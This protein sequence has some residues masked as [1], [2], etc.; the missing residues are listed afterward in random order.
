MSYSRDC[1]MSSHFHFVFL[2]VLIANFSLIVCKK[3]EA[4]HFVF[5]TIPVRFKHV[6]ETINSLLDQDIAPASISIFISDKYNSQSK[7]PTNQTNIQRFEKA[8]AHHRKSDKRWK[9]VHSLQVTRDFGPIQ[10]LLGI[11]LTYTNM[12]SYIS[13]KKDNYF[14][15]TDCD[16][17]YRPFMVQRYATDMK[18][19]KN[20]LSRVPTMFHRELRL[21]LHEWDIVHVQG[22]DTFLVTGKV[23]KKQLGLRQVFEPIT[24]VPLIDYIHNTCPD[25]YYQDDYV[26]TVLFFLGGIYVESIN[27]KRREEVYVYNYK[28]PQQMHQSPKRKEREDNTRKCLNANIGLFEKYLSNLKQSSRKSHMKEL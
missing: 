27:D 8:I 12:S 1:V 14:I 4:F 9:K 5:T 21:T 18:T 3:K 22:A 10:K 11:F 23:V 20:D 24:L 2:I 13:N 6:H 19:Y 26:I 25:S 16:L 7:A 15:I 17:N 28:P